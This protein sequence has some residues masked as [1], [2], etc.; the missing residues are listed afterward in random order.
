MPQVP[1]KRLRQPHQQ[2][3]N[4]KPNTKIAIRKLPTHILQAMH[5]SE[6]HKK[7]IDMMGSMWFYRA[8]IGGI[9][10]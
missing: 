9:L 8:Y 7:E 4:P 3:L 10:G 6:S 1:N 5:E 2:T